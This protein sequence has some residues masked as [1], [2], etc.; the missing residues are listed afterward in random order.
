MKSAPNLILIGPMG[1]GKSS[2]GRRLAQ[3]LGLPF[4]DVDREI[5]H[6]T[7]ASIPLIFELEGEEGFRERERDVLARVCAGHGQVI[8]TGG[9]AV[10]LPANRE[11]MPTRGFVVHLSV[12]LDNQLRRLGQDRNRPLLQHP[13]RRERLRQLGEQRAPLYAAV[14]DLEYDTGRSGVRQAVERLETLLQQH[15]QLSAP[16]PPAPEIPAPAPMDTAP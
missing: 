12:T 9:G 10:L 15:W 2:I 7:G 1:S 11:L 13:D 16:Q 6:A 14:A 8:A 5:E 4:V 3:R